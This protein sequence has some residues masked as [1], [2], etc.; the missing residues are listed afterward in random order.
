MSL[1]QHVQQILFDALTRHLPR[2]ASDF[3]KICRMQALHPFLIIVGSPHAFFPFLNAPDRETLLDA[4]RS[5]LDARSRQTLDLFMKRLA[6]FP[7]DAESYAFMSVSD[8]FLPRHQREAIRRWE[9]A[10]P[11]F[12]RQYRYPS[13]LMAPETFLEH[14]ALPLLP[15]RCL[16]YMARRDFLDLGAFIGDSVLILMNYEPKKIYAFDASPMNGRRFQHTMRRNHIPADRVEFVSMGVADQSGTVSFNDQGTVATTLA[17]GGTTQV[18][19]TT[20]DTF[21]EARHLQVGLIKM[22]IEGIGL[23]A[24]RGMVA[25]LKRD[26]PVLSLAVYHC[27]DELLLIKPFIESLGLGYRFMLR[28][29]SPRC[30]FME[31]RL[32]AYPGELAD[33]ST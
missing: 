26:R 28:D 18:K 14:Q 32:L 25:T 5:G 21:A 12:K 19:I 16:P 13:T 1:R 15:P 6:V 30:W 11:E 4:L 24:V 10:F 17:A 22:D 8:G 7:P 29:L 9:A 23:Q 27:P 20:I 33:A 31:T 3:L 2:R